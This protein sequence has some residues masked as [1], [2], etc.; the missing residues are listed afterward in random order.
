MTLFGILVVIGWVRRIF[1]ARLGVFFVA[2]AAD[3][4]GVVSALVDK[5]MHVSGDMC[6]D[7]MGDTCAA[8]LTALCLNC[9]KNSRT[10]DGAI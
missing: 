3:T 2:F 9:S 8:V 1:G 10:L 7:V 6:T 5:S 4:G